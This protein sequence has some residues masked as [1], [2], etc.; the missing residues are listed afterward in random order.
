MVTKNCFGHSRYWNIPQGH[1]CAAPKIH[2]C[3][4]AQNRF[5]SFFFSSSSLFS[6]IWIGRKNY[7]TI[8]SLHLISLGKLSLLRPLLLPLSSFILF[9]RKKYNFSLSIS[10]LRVPTALHQRISSPQIFT[11]RK[12]RYLS[13][14]LSSVRPFVVL[15]EVRHFFLFPLKIGK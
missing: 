7:C 12:K 2:V 5:F 15:S 8:C 10:L 4:K 3:S 9:E 14:L 1:S 13:F 11:R 6:L